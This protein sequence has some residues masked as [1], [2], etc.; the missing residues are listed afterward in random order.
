MTAEIIFEPDVK[1]SEEALERKR[2][3]QENKAK[4][5]LVDKM[6][7]LSRTTNVYFDDQ[8]QPNAKQNPPFL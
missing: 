7:T 1:V 8:G 4:N 6:T 2:R 3:F 5:G